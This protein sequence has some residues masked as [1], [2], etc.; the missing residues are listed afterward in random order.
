MLDHTT[1]CDLQWPDQLLGESHQRRGNGKAEDDHSKESVNRKNKR[2][3]RLMTERQQEW[4]KAEQP[5]QLHIDSLTEYLHMI[6][7]VSE[8]VVSQLTIKMSF[9]KYDI[10]RQSMTKLCDKIFIFSFFSVTPMRHHVAKNLD[11][12]YK[13]VTI[14]F[15]C[16]NTAV[17]SDIHA[18]HTCNQISNI[19][20]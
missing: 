10:A 1:G 14:N 15:N 20:P 8:W 19:F 2:S 11:V 4:Y 5:L 9:Y 16:Q 12:L 3:H 13:F 17:Y 7:R 6:Q 18:L